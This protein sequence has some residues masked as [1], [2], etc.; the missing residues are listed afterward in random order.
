MN[1]CGPTTQLKK[2]PITCIFEG[3][4]VGLSELS[5]NGMPGDFFCENFCSFLHNYLKG[6]RIPLCFRLSSVR[7]TGLQLPVK[8]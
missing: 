6:E 3:P 5:I 2:L 7:S 8:T 4:H 1:T